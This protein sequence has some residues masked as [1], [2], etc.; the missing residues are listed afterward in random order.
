MQETRAAVGCLHGGNSNEIIHFGQVFLGKFWGKV[1]NAFKQSIHMSFS[2]LLLGQVFW[3]N[4]RA[5]NYVKSIT[6][7][8]A[9]SRPHSLRTASTQSRMWQTSNSG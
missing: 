7:L 9:N 4:F 1:A 8:K 3:A 6:P 2:I 5:K